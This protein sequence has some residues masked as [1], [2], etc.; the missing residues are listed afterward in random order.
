M[1]DTEVGQAAQELRDVSVGFDVANVGQ[2][3]QLL[4]GLPRLLEA[5][6]V[7]GRCVEKKPSSTHWVKWHLTA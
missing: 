7:C 6:Q 4:G 3:G 2:L 1:Q 5:C